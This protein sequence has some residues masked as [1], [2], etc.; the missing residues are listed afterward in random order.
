[1]SFRMAADVF[2]GLPSPP[3]PRELIDFAGV[4]DV[5][6]T[7]GHADDSHILAKPLRCVTELLARA[8]D[9][10]RAARA[11]TEPEFLVDRN[12]RQRKCGHARHCGCATGDFDDSGAK[13][14]FRL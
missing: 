7:G 12:R 1:M 5:L 9:H 3:R 4:A 13:V 6:A 2:I 11:E 8:F 10:L 14:D